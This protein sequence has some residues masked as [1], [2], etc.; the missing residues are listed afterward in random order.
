MIRKVMLAWGCV[1][2]VAITAP[3]VLNGVDEIVE[4]ADDIKQSYHKYTA[5]QHDID[6]DS[7]YPGV[8]ED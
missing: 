1:A 7:A 3:A 5:K 6:V 4:F 2:F 8:K